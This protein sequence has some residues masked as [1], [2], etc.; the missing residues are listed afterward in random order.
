MIEYNGAGY[1]R[2]QAVLACKT[3]LN[4]FASVC[5]PDVYAFPFPPIFLAVW[6]MLTGGAI[7]EIGQEKLAIGLPRGFG[8]TILLKL[9]VVWLI[10]F[11]NRRFIL[12]VCN[13]AALAENFIS[14]VAD[15]LDSPNIKAIF[16]DWRIGM[17][18]D[19]APLKKFTFCGRNVSVAALGSGSSLRGL[20]IKFVRPDMMVMDDMQS[21]EEAESPVESEKGIKW[22][23]GTLLKANNKLRCL[24]CFIGNMYPYEGSILKK[25]KVNPGW[26]SFVTGA[27]LEDGQ[28]IWPEL[29]S[30]EDI[31]DELENDISM[32]HPEI[33][34]SEVMNDEEAGNKS[35]TDINR[36]GVYSQPHDVPEPEPEAGFVIIDPSM[37]K[38]QSDKIAIGVVLV[39]EGRP[40][41]WEVSVG[42]F[43]PKQCI[44]ECLRLAMKYGLMAVLVESVA[45][46][47]SLVF[48]MNEAKKRHGLHGLRILEIYPGISAKTARII[49]MLKQL[50]APHPDILLHPS[51]RTL[52][53]YQIV[54]W[55]PMRS[56]NVDDLLDILAYCYPAIKQ[57]GM[58]LLKPYALPPSAEAS[59]ADTLELGF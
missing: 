52:V 59:F 11:T 38:K 28:S 17:E 35:G 40:V 29:R 57:F 47:A 46:Q 50:T 18:K 45:Y 33:F 3:N 51:I 36:I 27:I 26:T 9:F 30:E 21:R 24:F 16:G 10:L 25:L 23:L 7:K 58:L 31:L 48:W 32:G 49:T 34:F 44:T 53:V 5:I 43:N 42:A 8:K 15:I 13:T 4:F 19:T 20:N 14:D 22:M 54:H 55:N 37:G 39:F 1:D 2:D 56:K 12:V 41:L 6:Q